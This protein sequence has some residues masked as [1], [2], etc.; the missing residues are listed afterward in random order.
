MEG[1]HADVCHPSI[2]WS[3][4]KARKVLLGH[5]L[6]L[7]VQ[8]LEGLLVVVGQR[9]GVVQSTQCFGQLHWWGGCMRAC[10]GSELGVLGPLG[11]E[12]LGQVIG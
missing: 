11:V 12:C 8:P 10:T 3:E 9:D 7:L 4:E 6:V 2:Y 1:G 5:H